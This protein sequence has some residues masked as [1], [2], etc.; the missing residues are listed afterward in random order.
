[1]V[2]VTLKR[3]EVAEGLRLQAADAWSTTPAEA[4]AF[5]AKEVTRW[6]QVVRDEKIS[7]QN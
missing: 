5:V 4:Q 3:P 2:R 6:T 1:M 7:A